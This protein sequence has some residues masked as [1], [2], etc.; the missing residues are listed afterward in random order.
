MTERIYT[1][2]LTYGQ[3]QTL[4]ALVDTARHNVETEGGEGA[5]ER[6]GILN[7]L[8]DVLLAAPAAV[9]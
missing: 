6:W 1:V 3:L 9:E 2:Q 8:T 5:T 7:D 4:I